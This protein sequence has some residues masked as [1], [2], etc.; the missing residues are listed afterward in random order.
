M[1]V[2]TSYGGGSLA[3]ANRVNASDFLLLRG[4][5]ADD[6]SRI[7]KMIQA[8]RT[9]ETR[10]PMPVLINEDDHFRF[11]E[12]DNH[13]SDY[14]GYQCPPVRANV[15]TKGGQFLPYRLF[16]AC[17]ELLT[18]RKFLAFDRWPCACSSLPE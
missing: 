1:L 2:G 11:N 13:K 15:P 17:A 3:T 16:P 9:L 12:P 5:G 10:V 18:S 6:P 14:V 8:S 4:N 7:R